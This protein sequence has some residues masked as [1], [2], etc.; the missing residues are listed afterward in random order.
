MRNESDVVG[1]TFLVLLTTV[2]MGAGSTF[3]QPN[4]P[5]VV[6]DNGTGTVTLPPEGCKYLSADQL[7]L[8]V[9]GL[10]V[11][12]EIKVL[13]DH[14]D[15]VCGAGTR[16]VALPPCVCLFPPGG[17]QDECFGSTL[18]LQLRGTG[19]LADFRRNLRLSD[20]SVRTHTYPRTPGDAVQTF[21]NE[22]VNLQTILTGDPDFDLLVITAGTANNLP[23]SGQTTLTRQGPPGSDFVVD[24]F[25]DMEY[26]IAFFGA[27]GSALQGLAGFTTS[28]VR[29]EARSAVPPPSRLYTVTDANRLAVVDVAAS[30]SATILGETKDFGGAVRRVRGLAYD[31]YKAI[32][33]GMTREGDL[34][35]VNRTSGVTKHVPLVPPLVGDFWGGLSFD[36]TTGLLYTSDAS[37]QHN[38][39]EIDPIAKTSTIVGSTASGGTLLQILGQD[40]YPSTAPALPPTFNST[41]PAPGVLYGS[42]RN[43]QN[44]AV[45]DR[46]GGAVSFPMGT[47]SIG[48]SNPQA[49]TFHPATGIL[50]AIHDHFSASNNAALSTYDFTT[51]MATELCELPFGIVESVGGGNDT[52]GWGGL[53]F[54]PD[55]GIFCDG[56][57]SGD[58]SAWM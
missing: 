18:L 24:S 57:E 12:T 38:L 26:R 31:P 48:V 40:L 56:F 41:H 34:V 2:L 3:G 8:I 49:I 13:A 50:Y 58:T 45:V 37:A 27:Q 20:V 36:D 5:C 39:V 51:E 55:C 52:Y 16:G 32:M 46:S 7:H 54:A 10:P 21:A 28:T 1:T 44:V 4:D 22:M 14:K 30:C 23:S 47:Q 6:A 42:N 9:D 43:N 15:Y 19:A 33:Y 17:G 53:A 25:F 29:V 11:G 35:T